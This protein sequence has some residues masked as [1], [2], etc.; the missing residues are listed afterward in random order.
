M[1][2][3]CAY[4]E[5]EFE[6]VDPRHKTCGKECRIARNKAKAKECRIKHHD[7]LLQQSRANIKPIF[8]K[9]C[10]KPIPR[11]VVGERMSRRRYHEKC[12]VEV[13]LQ[14]VS[15]GAKAK[16]KRICRAWNTY[17]YS[18]SELREMIERE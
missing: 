11:Y 12:V 6:P 4:C 10:G 16:D 9:I 3:Q 15:E 13:A 2:K 5:K 18:M 1:I 8:C 17:G 14:A 7:E